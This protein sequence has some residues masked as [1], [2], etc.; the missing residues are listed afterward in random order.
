MDFAF[1]RAL[2][3]ATY[4]IMQEFLALN[5]TSILSEEP[6]F[7]PTECLW[8]ASERLVLLEALK[9]WITKIQHNSLKE[10]LAFT[11]LI[12]KLSKEYYWW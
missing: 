3:H 8:S 12:Y 10:N 6:S 5:P 1:K 7:S 4:Y 11:Q 9:K 2:E